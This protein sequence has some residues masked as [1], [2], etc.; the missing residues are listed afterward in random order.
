MAKW[1]GLSFGRSSQLQ[2]S[3]KLS[4]NRRHRCPIYGGYDQFLGVLRTDG[5]GSNPSENGE[6]G[7]VT[8]LKRKIN[9]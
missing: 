6:K 4:S 8:C 1:L 2:R 7:R 9:V 5:F 3:V